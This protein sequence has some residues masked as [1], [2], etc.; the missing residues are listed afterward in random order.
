MIVNQGWENLCEGHHIE[1]FNVVREFFTNGKEALDSRCYV[2]GWLHNRCRKVYLLFFKLHYQSTTFMGS[3]HPS[4]K[5]LWELISVTALREKM[6]S[7][8]EFYEKSKE[9]QAHY[10]GIEEKYY[11]CIYFEIL[12][13]KYNVGIRHYKDKLFPSKELD[14]RSNIVQYNQFKISSIQYEGESSSS[15]MIPTIIRYAYIRMNLMESLFTLCYSNYSSPSLLVISI[16]L[17]TLMFI[18]PNGQF[19]KN[20]PESHLDRPLASA[21]QHF[22]NRIPPRSPI[23][24]SITKSHFGR[25]L[26][27]A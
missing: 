27:S 16:M 22:G 9:F 12:S 21:S 10:L 20:L 1:V 18:K 8:I 23:V 7:V 15:Q 24:V 14:I 4:L 2:R 3:G 25:P 26:V 19:L 5:I 6:D 11:H 17:K 13:K